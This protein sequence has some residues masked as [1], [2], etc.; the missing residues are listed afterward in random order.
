MYVSTPFIIS[1]V[2]EFSGRLEKKKDFS[3]L[4]PMLPSIG[5]ENTRY[6]ERIH[7]FRF[8]LRTILKV[9]SVK[10]FRKIKRLIN[11]NK[12]LSFSSPDQSNLN[13]ENVDVDFWHLRALWHFDRPS[14]DLWPLVR[15]SSSSTDAHTRLQQDLHPFIRYTS[16]TSDA[17]IMR[18]PGSV[19][20]VCISFRRACCVCVWE[21]FLSYVRTHIHIY[22]SRRGEARARFH[23][24][25]MAA[26]TLKRALPLSYA[27]AYGQ[28][29]V[30]NTRHPRSRC[31]FFSSQQRAREKFPRGDRKLQ[32]YLFLNDI[33]ISFNYYVIYTIFLQVSSRFQKDQICQV[34]LP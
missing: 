29:R 10:I 11:T 28:S 13:L 34:W 4:I 12:L 8:Y 30:R 2:I 32:T 27:S 21:R 23:A 20:R 7:K 5:L 6:P 9:P 25:T 3:S 17:F 26:V 22:R 1:T 24:W 16:T 33:K 31:I 19:M 14:A 15:L 18:P